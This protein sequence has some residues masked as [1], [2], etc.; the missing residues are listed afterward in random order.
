MGNEKWTTGDNTKLLH[1][2]RLSRGPNGE[3][4]AV[5]ISEALSDYRY[6]TFLPHKLAFLLVTNLQVLCQEVSLLTA[7]GGRKRIACSQEAPNRGSTQEHCWDP[8]YIVTYPQRRE[9][10]AV[11]LGV[12]SHQFGRLYPQ[13]A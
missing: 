6:T 10:S 5:D 2:K 9:Y 3:V 11:V 7:A 13:I 8:R 1:R 12:V 4:H